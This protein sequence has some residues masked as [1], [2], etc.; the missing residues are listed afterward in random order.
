MFLTRVT[1]LSKN[2]GRILFHSIVKKSNYKIEFSL[3]KTSGIT[4]NK[5]ILLK[6]GERMENDKKQPGC[7]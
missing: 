3:V 4:E 2:K 7:T 1:F 6:H 5:I